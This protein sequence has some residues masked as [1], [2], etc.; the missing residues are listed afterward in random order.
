M[1]LINDLHREEIRG[2]Y[3]V[4]TRREWVPETKDKFYNKDLCSI[5]KTSIG[6]IK[7]TQPKQFEKLENQY[8]PPDRGKTAQT[9]IQ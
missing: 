2:S 5:P 9:D 6:F 1:R 4:R 7:D 3:R 8:G